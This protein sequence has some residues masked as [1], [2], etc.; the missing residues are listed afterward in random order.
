MKKNNIL[1]FQLNLYSKL[2]TFLIKKGKKNKANKIIDDT[3]FTLSKNTKYSISNLFYK[4]FYNLNTF[5]EAKLIRKHR[6]SYIVPFFNKI[7]RR[8]YLV[9]K[10]LLKSISFNKNKVPISQKIIQE[11]FLILKNKS[12]SKSLKFKSSNN[13][14]VIANRSNLHYRW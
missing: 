11:I 3:F 5:I 7:P 12:F 4:L 8:S 9:I 1:G 14:K 6:R 13:K 2:L 10:W